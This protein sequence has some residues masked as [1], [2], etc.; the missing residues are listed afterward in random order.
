MLAAASAVC[1]PGPSYGGETSTTSAPT[2]SILR[3]A[4]RKASASVVERPPTSG[5]PVPGAN[6]GSR[7]STSKE[8]KTGRLP[9]RVDTSPAK[10]PGPSVRSCS[11][12]RT[13]KPP[14]PGGPCLPA[15]EAPEAHPAR[16][17]VALGRVERAAQARLHRHGRLDQLL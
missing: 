8:R 2:R 1:C 13:A 11:H 4:R 17:L 10:L 5:V 6:A 16:R 12:G 7:T 3:N 15:G 14:G 9:T